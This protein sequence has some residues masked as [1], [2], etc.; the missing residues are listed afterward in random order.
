MSIKPKPCPFCGGTRLF[1]SSQGLGGGLAV[2]MTSCSKCEAEGPRIYGPDDE[3]ERLNSE[4]LA[5]W[6]KSLGASGALVVER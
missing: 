2:Y 1:H 4:A 6:N 3:G 5:L